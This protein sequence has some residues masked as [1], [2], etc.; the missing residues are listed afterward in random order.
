MCRPPV[1]RGSWRLPRQCPRAAEGH[2]LYSIWPFCHHLPRTRATP[3]RCP[4]IAVVNARDRRLQEPARIRGEPMSKHTSGLLLVGALISAAAVSDPAAAD[5]VIRIGAVVDQSGGST[6]P[7]Y[8]A[9]IELAGRQMNEALAKAHSDVRFEIVFGDSKSNPPFARQEALRLINQHG[10]KAL[11]ADSSGVTVAINGLN[12]DPASPANDKVAITCFQC[13]SSFINDPAV[14]ESD[15]QVQA[16]ERDLDNWLYRVFYVAKYEAAALTQIALNRIRKG[17]AP[18]KI[19]IFADGGHRALATDI[20]RIVPWFHKGPFTVKTVYTAGRD[21]IAEEWPKVIDDKDEAGKINGPPDVAIVAMLPDPAAIAVKTYAEGG[22][23]IPLL[24]NNSFRR[25][26]ILK[27]VG[28]AANGVEGS[29]VTQIDKGPSG[30]MFVEAFKAATGE[31]P[32][33]TSSGAYDSAV[34]LMLA[35]LTASGAGKPVD[36]AAIRDGLA[37]INEKGGATIRPGVD[38]FAA[39]ARAASE[40]KPIDYEGAY[41]AIDWEAAGDMFPPIVHWKIEDSKFVEYELY[42]CTPAEPRCPPR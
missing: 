27:Q 20:P 10:A 39:A 41:H 18:V 33:M 24:S 26:Y 3:L 12:Y 13:S 29:S 32:E 34:T 30:R 11:V 42:H 14:T 19:A 8:R 36:A 1:L 22:Y 40:G 25:D 21:K 6:S 16:A 4:L 31:M 38:G 37:R 2:A 9:A 15:P 7:H 35:A 23:K 28:A 17:D 5:S